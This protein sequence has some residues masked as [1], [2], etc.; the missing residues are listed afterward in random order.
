MQTS[1]EILI[2]TDP[3]SWFMIIMRRQMINNLFWWELFTFNLKNGEGMQSTYIVL[4]CL[5]CS[6]LEPKSS[7]LWYYISLHSPFTEGSSL[8]VNFMVSVISL[9]EHT[10]TSGY[11]KKYTGGVEGE[12]LF[13]NNF[14]MHMV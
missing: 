7:P 12:L 2:E 8:V 1:S 10:R 11:Q 9:D 6:N 3:W 14:Q 13:Q 5:A 4:T